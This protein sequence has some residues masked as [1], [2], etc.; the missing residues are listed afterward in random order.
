MHE[1]QALDLD[2]K[3]H[4]KEKANNKNKSVT[5]RFPEYVE[6]ESRR[7]SAMYIREENTPRIHAKPKLT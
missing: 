1:F 3:I 4:Q 5:P 7:E 6:M 2:L